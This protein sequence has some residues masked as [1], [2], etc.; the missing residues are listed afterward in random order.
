MNPV[1]PRVDILATQN[2]DR[3]LRI[4]KCRLSILT[5]ECEILIFFKSTSK[6]MILWRM[7][8]THSI[9]VTWKYCSTTLATS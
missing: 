8:A 4:D 1:V 5:L 6:L 7:N 9:S 2:Y 3:K